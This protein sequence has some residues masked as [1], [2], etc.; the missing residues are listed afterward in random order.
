MQPERW[1][2]IEDLVHSAYR[3]TESERAQFL[4]RNILDDVD[5]RREV[6]SLLTQLDAAPEFLEAPLV[7]PSRDVIAEAEQIGPYRLIRPL[8]EGGMGTVYLASREQEEYR[9]FVALKMLRR[10]LDTDRLLERF[11]QERRIL[12]DLSHP[13]IAHFIDSGA[14]PNSRPFI[15]MEFVDGMPLT[16]Y[17][18]THNLPIDKRLELFIDVCEAVHYAHRHLVIHRD[19]KPSN[20][21]VTAD[22]HVK[23]LD[24]G[25]AKS[26][27]PDDTVI[28]SAEERMLTPQY[29]APEQILG[30]PTTIACDIYSLG[31][32]LYEL[33][34]GKLPYDLTGLSR[35]EIERVVENQ[36]PA[37]PSQ[38]SSS[39]GDERLH[40]DLDYITHAALR[41]EPERR[42]ASAEQLAED[43]RRH[44]RG[45]PVWAGPEKLSYVAK[46][47]I[48]RYRAGVT[49][50]VAIIVLLLAFAIVTTIQSVKISRHATAVE[51]QQERA[52][53]VVLFLTDLFRASDP[54]ET[55]GELVT[56]RELLF[57]GLG[58]IDN[59]LADQPEIQAELLGVIADVSETLGLYEDAEMA[60]RRSL[61]LY[62]TLYEPRDPRVATALNTLGWI[63]FQ[64]GQ[65]DE[66]ARY[67]DEALTLRRQILPHD[68]PDVAR[69]LNDF[70]VL[71]QSMGNLDSTEVLLTEA[72][73]IRRNHFG[74]DH[75]AVA[76]TF[77]N[78][79]ALL[80]QRGN[81]VRAEE[82]YREALD[83]F[84]G[85]RHEDHPQVSITRNNLAAVR[86]TIGHFAEAEELYRAVLNTR[87]RVLGNDHPDV[88][89]SANTLAGVLMDQQNF[90]AADPLIDEAFAIR[91]TALGEEHA[92]VA[93]TLLHRARYLYET[94]QLAASEDIALDALARLQRIVGDQH[95]NTAAAHLR[96][97]QIYL[98]DGRP[99]PAVTHLREA[100]S[101]YLDVLAPTH[102]NTAL[103]AVYL[104]EALHAIGQTEE[105]LLLAETAAITLGD[106]LPP[107]HPSVITARATL[108][109][110]QLS[111]R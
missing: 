77:N 43:I 99:E 82:T 13:G 51:L 79:A 88:A 45:M 30:Q 83:I 111:G 71:M 63:L 96:L 59:E 42:Y 107:S 72:L 6:E 34:T 23:L 7:Q 20:I 62:R 98:R 103:S 106:R 94:G 33:L 73:A 100:Y 2:Q 32:I 56:A 27:A 9:Q 54:G 85:L 25:I 91:R 5:L 61:E 86:A 38:F 52:E 67:L 3:Y 93:V 40:P 47:F 4:D 35:S 58:R 60:A 70:A 22:G 16:T 104:A 50:A 81:Y 29:S 1:Q 97:G 41:K 66:S 10:G 102:T 26:L 28:T 69:T 109:A 95:V 11:A 89:A 18:K 80:W 65:L 105:A 31:V 76:V 53:Q 15:V 92:L 75:L 14:T 64:R 55:R 12:A 110:I 78:V 8:G 24:F 46:K 101:I 48:A 84:L 36:I 19:L 37:S 74:N 21:F 87:R 44:Q 68:H 90:E 49:A 39:Q 108:D 17:C 57:R